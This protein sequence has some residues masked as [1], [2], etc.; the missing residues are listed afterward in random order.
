MAQRKRLS[1]CFGTVLLAAIGAVFLSLAV[2]RYP[3]TWSG[4]WNDP[5]M[6]GI[7]VQ[8]R[9]AR[10]GMALLAG[11]TLGIA[12]SVYQTVFQ[13]PLAAPDIIGVASGASAGA[14]AAI[15]FFGGGTVAVTLM[16]FAGGS[17]AVL[18]ALLLAAVAR[19]RGI[20][21]LVLSGIVVSALAQSL[22]MLMKLT[23]DPERELSS[24][25]FW[26]MGS[27]ADITAGKALGVVPWILAGLAGLFLLR[28]QILLLGLPEE[29]A[30]MLGC[31]VRWMRPA[32][33]LLATLATGAVI[34]VTGLI[35]FI[36]LLA[37]HIARLLTGSSRFSTTVLSG[38]CGGVLLLLSDVLARSLGGGEIPVSIITSLM[39]APF[40]F[41]LMCRKGRGL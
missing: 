39:G 5:Y 32:V 3:I 12:G 7:F 35:S 18:T 26:T 23:A 13:N 17:A 14:A 19:D 41:W 36:G 27:F 15:L 33:L 34:A 21:N 9:M 25:E 10:T 30:R 16:A 8:L 40:L 24:I 22:L 37:P 31:P 38:L 20:A 2:G 6:A 29:D 11:V 4:L 28:R 1:L